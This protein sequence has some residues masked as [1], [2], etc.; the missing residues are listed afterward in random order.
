M[1]FLGDHLIAQ[2]DLFDPPLQPGEAYQEAMGLLTIIR[3]NKCQLQPSCVDCL[4]TLILSDPCHST[5]VKEREFRILF[6]GLDNAGKSTV[7]KKV[8]G[9]PIDTISPTLGFDIK[10][11]LHKGCV[12][13]VNS[14]C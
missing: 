5:T 1:Q 7:I 12:F 8:N 4:L 6:L 11:F 2:S 13:A 14:A 10:T 3:K 9:E